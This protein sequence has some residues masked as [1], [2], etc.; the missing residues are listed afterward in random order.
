M[1][2]KPA[3]AAAAEPEVEKP[4]VGYT[5]DAGDEVKLARWKRAHIAALRAADELEA[6]RTD[7]HAVYTDHGAD[8][9]QCSLGTLSLGGRKAGTAYPWKEIAVDG[10]SEAKLEKL[11]AKHGTSV[12]AATWPV[13]PTGWGVE[14]KSKPEA[15]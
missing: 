5:A 3:A 11:K 14:A 4:K 10:I 1:P 8:F 9:V 6:A 12:D 7:A 2:K 15:A 13:A